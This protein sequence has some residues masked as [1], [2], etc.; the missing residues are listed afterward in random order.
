MV[1]VL[2]FFIAMRMTMS[3]RRRMVT[4]GRKRLKNM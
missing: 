2:P 1:V 4:G 3:R